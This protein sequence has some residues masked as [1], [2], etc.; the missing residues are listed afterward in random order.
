MI[1]ENWFDILFW[2]LTIFNMFVFIII[3]QSKM[4]SN[5]SVHYDMGPLLLPWFNFNPSMDK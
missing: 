5:I 1:P 2:Y 4:C 3:V